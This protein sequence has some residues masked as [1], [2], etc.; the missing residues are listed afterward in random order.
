MKKEAIENFK[1]L[2]V[3]PQGRSRLRSPP[4]HDRAKESK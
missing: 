2:T 4:R 3:F 1:F